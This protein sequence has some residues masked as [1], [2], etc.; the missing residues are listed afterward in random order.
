MFWV[1]TSV[2]IFWVAIA[3][4]SCSKTQRWLYRY[5]VEIKIKMGAVRARGGRKWE[6]GELAPRFPPLVDIS[7]T[8]QI[9]VTL[10]KIRI[11]FRSC[12]VVYE[13]KKPRL[14]G[15]KLP[16]LFTLWGPKSRTGDRGLP[17]TRPAKVT[18]NKTFKECC[19]ASNY[20]FEIGLFAVDVTRKITD[21][22]FYSRFFH[23]EHLWEK[24]FL[25]PSASCGVVI[26]QS[27]H[28]ESRPRGP[29]ALLG[30]VCR[31]NSIQ[32]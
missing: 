28:C 13:A 25:G 19:S 3:S 16:K 23:S 7:L 30:I 8:L 5:A 20:H 1:S 12:S 4:R 32:N 6:K 22:P 14:P 27:G 24:I 11:Q 10:T 21:P 15:C 18:R 31:V 29:G 2:D 9:S 17:L 26:T